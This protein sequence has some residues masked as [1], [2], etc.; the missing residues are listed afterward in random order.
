[1][2]GRTDGWTNGRMDGC[3]AGEFGR[4]TQLGRQRALASAAAAAAF[5]SFSHAFVRLADSL[6]LAGYF[7]AAS[8]ATLP[9]RTISGI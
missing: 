3:D 2:D 6:M 4:G 9:R 7:M 8:S 5:F 1:M